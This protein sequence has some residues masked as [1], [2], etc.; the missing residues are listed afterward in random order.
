M[1][2][3][4]SNR[5][6]LPEGERAATVR[7]EDGVI[8]ELG[9]GAAD[10]DFGD[11][12][13]LPGLVDSHVHVNEPG[14]THWEGF[15]T[16]T[17]AAVAGGTTTI[18]D[19][20]LNSIPPT[21]DPEALGLKRRAATGAVDCDVAFWGGVIPGSD[22][23]VPALVENGVCGFKVFTVESG[24]EEFPPL[25]YPDIA[26]LSRDL[27]VHDV[28]LLLHAEDPSSLRPPVGDPRVYATYL[29]TRPG[30][31]EGRA[32]D[33]AG[34]VAAESGVHLHIL[35][36]AGADAVEALQRATARVTAE[37]C[38]HYLTFDA[39]AIPGGATAYKCAPP[40]RD[41]SH[42][43][44]LWE[45]LEDGTISMVVSDHSPAPPEAKD[46]SGG[47]FLRAWGGI[48]SIELRLVATWHGARQRGIRLGRL[49]DWLAGAPAQLAGLASR[50]GAIAEGRDADLVVFDPDGATEVDAAALL[51]RHPVTP[52]DGMLL[53]G[54]VVATYLRGVAV[55][56]PGADSAPR[57]E[58]LVRGG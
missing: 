11:L 18:V 45:A 24:V 8:V 32:I 5:V 22:P 12:A 49:V 35:H 16:A 34:R 50:K 15:H 17:A 26:T 14:R 28:P 3:I 9:E 48:A 27:A 2:T 21:V 57:G 19:M 44:A 51:Q 4:R 31:A 43:E 6:F 52:Y 41:R 38:P 29:A 36:V 1:P 53:A 42:R 56:G 46:L 33:D 58:L 47:D 7:I 10:D 39:D 37:T 23:H 25:T 55:H 40:I 20:P 30:E 54:A 13:I